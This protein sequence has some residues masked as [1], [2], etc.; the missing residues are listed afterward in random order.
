MLVF[1]DETE[2]AVG[3][4]S[5]SVPVTPLDTRC[6]ESFPSLSGDRDLRP[7]G[8]GGRSVQYHGNTR[9]NMTEENFPALH[10]GTPN[11]TLNI[12]LQRGTSQRPTANNYANNLSIKVSFV[13]ITLYCCQNKKATLCLY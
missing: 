6:P 10:G 7:S 1:R 3:Y 12:S 9:F 8:M 4:S 2:G 13:L 5:S 11:Q